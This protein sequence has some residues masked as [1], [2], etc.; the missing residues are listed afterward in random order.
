MPRLVYIVT[1]P[2]SARLLMR[3]QL[4][5][6][7][8]R[9]FEVTVISAPGEDLHVAAARE[10]VATVT[11][12]FRREIDPLQD[13]HVLRRLY[14][15]LRRL[16]PDI[17]NASTPKAGLLGMMV[18]R[19][20]HV[21]VRLYTLRGLRLETA[22]GWARPVLHAT[23][24]L[25]SACAHHVLAVSRSLR[26]AYLA[27]GLAPPEKLTV[28]A[29]GSS[30]G[31]DLDRFAATPAREDAARALRR[32]LGI[33]PA[34]APVV[35]FVGRFTRDKGIA[36]LIEAFQV[37][38]AHVPEARLLLVGD[39]EQGD[40]VPA[41]TVRALAAHPQVIQTGFVPDAAPY[42]H[43]MDV[44]AFPSRREGFPNVPLEAAAAGVP[45][46]G[47][48]ATGTVDAVVHGATGTLVPQGDAATLGHTLARYL[49]NDALRR[50]HGE[51]ARARA[52]RAFR[53]ERIWQALYDTYVRLLRE[54]E[55]PLPEDTAQPAVAV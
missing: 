49:T 9:G 55:R 33:P 19:A 50:T 12:P 54:K 15:M 1:H 13:A 36:D 45:T 23:E 34:R 8:R 29:D 53:P 40:P 14:R 22:A 25:T 27:H 38:R 16:Q 4:A 46:V 51:A 32:R 21:P 42:Y 52:E 11:L 17:V 24:R 10:G 18:A 28:L 7:R 35:G 48:F 31:I 26:R 44:L 6:M 5:Y 37:A 2:M 41:P 30:N 20:A 43:V 39:F 3:G 47:A